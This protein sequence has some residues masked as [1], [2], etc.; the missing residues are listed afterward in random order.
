MTKQPNKKLYHRDLQSIRSNKVKGH[1][2]SQ[3]TVEVIQCPLVLEGL[4]QHIRLSKLYLSL[5]MHNRTSYTLPIQ[6]K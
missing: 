6:I 3:L 5:N 1:D 2:L 4:T